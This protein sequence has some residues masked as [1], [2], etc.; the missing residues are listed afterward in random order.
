MN[1]ISRRLLPMN[2]TLNPNQPHAPAHGADAGDPQGGPSFVVAFETE[3]GWTA[4]C[5]GVCGVAALSFG[6]QSA[7][8]AR[9]SAAE[10]LRSAGSFRRRAAAESGPT[11]QKTCRAELMREIPPNAVSPGPHF[12][13]DRLIERLQAFARG[14]PDD[15]CDVPVDFGR[16]TDFARRVWTA[17]RTIG[18]GTVATYA[19]LAL[20]VGVPRAAR[21]VGNALAANRVPLIIPCHRVI[22]RGGQIGRYSAPGGP[23]MKRRLLE[24]EAVGAS[25]ARSKPRDGGGLLGCADGYSNSRG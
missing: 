3:L 15:F 16:A 17:C 24:L 18:Y 25:S 21:A 13:I 12:S 2:R 4:I 14:V 22:A 11:R 19:E 10:S 9:R 20:R 1:R 23:L 8:A 7:E 6:H 5:G